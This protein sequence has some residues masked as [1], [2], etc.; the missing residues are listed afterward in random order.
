[1]HTAGISISIAGKDARIHSTVE[2]NESTVRRPNLWPRIR[3][4]AEGLIAERRWLTARSNEDGT[5]KRRNIRNL[6]GAEIVLIRR[7]FDRAFP[8]R[9]LNICPIVSGD[10]L[11]AGRKIERERPIAIADKR[12]AVAGELVR[13]A[14]VIVRLQ[15]S[16][17][18][19]I[20]R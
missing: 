6:V 17:A 8:A 4:L 3:I 19:E 1:M 12:G 10:V 16:D 18:G 5:A 7:R 15:I 9:V 13:G 2:R 14:V 11:R 20:G